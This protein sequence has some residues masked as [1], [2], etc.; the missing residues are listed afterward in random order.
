MPPNLVIFDCDGVLVDSEMIA[1]QVLG[2]QLSRLG[3][4]LS[5]A[6]CRERFTGRSL[7]SVRAM[8]EKELGHPLAHDF[9]EK[10]KELDQLAF[11]KDLKAVTGIE[12]ALRA[13][14]VPVCVASSGSPE[15][16]NTSLHLT[17]LADFFGG[18][19]FSSSMVA[20]G[21]PAPDLFN[22]A[23][24]RM[25]T[26]VDQIVVI[27]DSPCGVIAAGLANMRVFG[28][29][30]ASHAKDDPLFET[31]LLNAGADLVFDDMSRL[32]Q[33]LDF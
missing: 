10:L 14:P 5:A 2:E 32:A 29:S 13:I 30:G 26:P 11:E 33:L 25:K 3:L 8:V 20:N 9:E 28:F 23:A 22:F 15:K 19:L 1:S 24:R 4:P 21:K 18:N 27:E 16:I 17:G 6:E 7:R 12:G 31:K